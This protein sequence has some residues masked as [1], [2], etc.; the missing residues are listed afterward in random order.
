[1]CDAVGGAVSATVG[2][3]IAVDRVVVYIHVCVVAQAGE[4]VRLG[5]TARDPMFQTMASLL[6]VNAFDDEHALRLRCREEGPL[7]PQPLQSR[8]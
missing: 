6:D 8:L 5:V 1:M 4:F 2:T 7:L 3:T